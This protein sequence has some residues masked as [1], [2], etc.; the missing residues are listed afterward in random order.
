MCDVQVLIPEEDDLIFYYPEWLEKRDYFTKVNYNDIDIAEYLEDKAKPQI[1]AIYDAHY[2][3]APRAFLWVDVFKQLLNRIFDLD[4]AITLLFHEAGIYWSEMAQ[5]DHWKAVDLFSQ[6]FVDARKG[7]VRPILVSQLE[8]EVSYT[9]RNKCMWRIHRKGLGTHNQA[10]P[11]RKVIPFTAL[12]E[13]HLQFGGIYVR[14]NIA[15]LFAEKKEIYKMIPRRYID[16]VSLSP[17]GGGKEST[18]WINCSNCGHR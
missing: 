17:D 14:Y 4:S 6:F 3:I 12:D 5:G 9:I 13:Y 18:K 15:D 11:L 1:L 10:E 8:T 7:L 2:T 16:E